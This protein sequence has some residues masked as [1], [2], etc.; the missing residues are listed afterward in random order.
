M[1]MLMRDSKCHI[2][3]E[4]VPELAQGNN[5]AQGIKEPPSTLAY[6]RNQLEVCTEEHSLIN[7]LVN[8]NYNLCRKRQGGN[9]IIP[10][11]QFSEWV[12]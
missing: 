9:V 8:L 6:R 3:K 4:L 1:K 5:S 2:L 10:F 11:S 12:T 7:Y